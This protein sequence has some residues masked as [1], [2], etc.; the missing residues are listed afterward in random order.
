MSLFEELEVIDWAISERLQRN[1]GVF[2]GSTSAISTGVLHGK[3]RPL[4]EVMLQRH[5]IDK[6]IKRYKTVGQLLLGIVGLEELQQEIE[7]V[8]DPKMDLTA[9]GA[10]VEQ[11]KAKLAS[12]NENQPRT[13]LV[14]LY[15]MKGAGDVAGGAAGAASGVNKVL[16]R[17][18]LAMDI[19]KVFLLEEQYGRYLDLAGFH[20]QWMNLPGFRHDNS[21]S[22]LDYLA[23]FNKLGLK[24]QQDENNRNSDLRRDSR[25]YRDY[26]RQLREYLEGFLRKTRV[27]EGVERT[28]YQIQEVEF[29]KE[30]K[31]LQEKYISKHD[32]GIYCEACNKLFAKETVYKSHLSGKKHK[33]KAQEQGKLGATKA[34]GDP[35]E[36]CENEYLIKAYSESLE[37]VIKDT[38]VNVERRQ[39]LTNKERIDEMNHLIDHVE[40]SSEEEVEEET[41]PEDDETY[42][43]LNLPLDVDGKPIPYWLWKLQGLDHEH[44][45]EICGNFK[46]AGRKIFDK[47]FVEQRHIHGLKCLGINFEAAV[48]NTS[49]SELIL[50]FRGITKINE[51]TSLWDKMKK[52]LRK[53]THTHDNIV[54]VED[55]EGNVMSEKVYEDLKRQGLI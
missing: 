42:N 35:R 23:V 4:K 15:R 12:S 47:H 21:V 48:G 32:D 2:V 22:Y 36:L 6:F 39:A 38:K 31:V 8:R 33:K 11:L 27:L 46:Y 10:A 20:E 41:R 1:P 14:D 54:E 9:F 51:A 16:S 17:F 34:S 5:E 43:P 24:Y 28:L 30:W 29:P 53:K 7:A 26:A 13:Q 44:E 40:T 19:D 3:K 49:S 37:K 52:D 45:C 50:G 55:D 25:E 18:S